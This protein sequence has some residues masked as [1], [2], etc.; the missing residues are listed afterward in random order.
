MPN[1]ILI[2]IC[3]AASALVGFF[4]AKAHPTFK[5]KY[6]DGEEQERNFS[7]LFT[8]ERIPDL[9]H[10]LN[11]NAPFQLPRQHNYK[12]SDIVQAASCAEE[13]FAAQCAYYTARAEYAKSNALPL[14][15]YGL[16]VFISG[17]F[18]QFQMNNSSLDFGFV[19]FLVPL[20]LLIVSIVLFKKSGTRQQLTLTSPS[21]RNTEKDSIEYYTALK[22]NTAFSI[23]DAAAKLR[24]ARK[25]SVI[26]T[27]LIW[28]FTALLFP[29]AF[30]FILKHIF[31][32][33]A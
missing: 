15:N 8:C 7:S 6:W 12:E 24:N 16:V 20:A 23:F 22:Y 5:V 32:S 30:M 3:C 27:A 25:N 9:E 33:M 21:V 18:I 13:Y 31:T 29:S 4:Y 11:P 14:S 17:M 2:L 19:L 10:E 1:G 28:L 26:F